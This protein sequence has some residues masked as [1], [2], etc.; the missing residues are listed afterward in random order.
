[1][2]KKKVLIVDF[3]V[4]SA[5]SLGAF[6]EEEGFEVI[7]ACDG[8]A[9]L[10]NVKQ[11]KPDL[12]ILEP[13]LP[14]LHGFELCGIITRDLE[15]R[16]PVIILT[17]FYR[18]EQF[19]IES[20]RSF[21][22]SAFVSKPFERS[23]LRRLIGELIGEEGASGDELNGMEIPEAFAEETLEELKPMDMDSVP[24]TGEE[25]PQMMEPDE[26]E[27]KEVES[28]ESRPP[29]LELEEL[30]PKDWEAEESYPVDRNLEAAEREDLTPKEWQPEDPGF[31]DLDPEGDEQ[32]IDLEKEFMASVSNSESTS[33]DRRAENDYAQELDA[34]LEDAFSEF[35]LR[36]SEKKTAAPQTPASE[37][38]P[39]EAEPESPPQEDVLEKIEEIAQGGT[40]E[41]DEE[42]SVPEEQSGKSREDVVRQ[43]ETIAETLEKEL[44]IKVKG[45]SSLE[46]EEEVLEDAVSGEVE[47]EAEAAA[48]VEA[49]EASAASAGEQESIRPALK[50]EEEPEEVFAAFEDDEEEKSGAGFFKHVLGRL[51]GASP[52]IVVPL[53]AVFVIIILSLV[54]ILKPDKAEDAAKRQA[55]FGMTTI[56]QPLPGTGGGEERQAGEG[57]RSDGDQS[58]QDPEGS[59]AT[60]GESP[61]SDPV[62]AEKPP[63]E[64]APPPSSR[65]AVTAQIQEAEITPKLVGDLTPRQEAEDQS[66]VSQQLPQNRSVSS[67]VTD[68]AAAGL[69]ETVIPTT[70]T[71]RPEESPPASLEAPKI[72]EGDIVSIQQVDQE[73]EAIHKELPRF[74]AA[75]RGRGVSGIVMINAL[76]SET[77]D[78]IQTVVIRRLDSP[79]GFNQAAETA[80]KKW[81]FSPALKDGVRVKVWKAIPIAFRE[82]MD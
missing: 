62:S 15:P 61:E 40:P 82:N 44:E 66:P 79:Y 67:A 17:K 1:M 10:K 58:V 73:P 59:G 24:R 50:E 65:P 33:G 42:T 38:E 19:K 22:A 28:G 5:Q 76:I 78:V 39:A 74:P 46:P 2:T 55:S 60:R 9:G 26:Q 3:D 6:L 29:A 69:A 21:G 68:T 11:E 48:P 56:G 45:T 8:E 36:G 25:A 75:A 47:K 16:I 49:K 77:G 34:M 23:E 51:R 7:A 63:A 27:S 18:E 31:Q 14:K 71:G 70:L 80:V 54:F 35:G 64:P 43:A 37:S 53:A 57:S 32:T 13:M 4:K 30:K 20:L 81:K 52:K 12:V 72:R 41:A